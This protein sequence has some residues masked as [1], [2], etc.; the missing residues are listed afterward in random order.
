MSARKVDLL[1]L[2]LIQ[3]SLLKTTPVWVSELFTNEKE[4]GKTQEKADLLASPTP[5]FLA[6]T[7][8]RPEQGGRS[9]ACTAGI[10]AAA[11]VHR[12]RSAAG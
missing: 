8:A 2:S 12:R 3:P 6:F 11:A 10:V 5:Y 7:P 1:G 9:V 4:K